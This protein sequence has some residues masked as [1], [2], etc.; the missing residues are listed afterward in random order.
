MPVFAIQFLNTNEVWVMIKPDDIEA[1]MGILEGN[2][3][4]YNK[5]IDVLEYLEENVDK[6][7]EIDYNITKG[8][9]DVNKS[10]SARKAYLEQREKEREQKEK[11]YKRKQREGR[12]KSWQKRNSKEKD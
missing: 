1:F 8:N 10:L 2:K 5:R 12:N 9:K 7:E 11:E 4:I 6:K 3:E